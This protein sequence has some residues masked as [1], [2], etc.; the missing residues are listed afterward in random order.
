MSATI[1][2]GGPAFPRTYSTDY[3]SNS[4]AMIETSG[5][6]S[7]RDWFAGQALAGFVSQPDG[8]YSFRWKNTE[9]GETRFLGYGANPAGPNWVVT[10]TAMEAMAEA[11]YKH[12][13]AMIAARSGGAQ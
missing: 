7:L 1:N 6:M 9:T 3:L 2:D 5:G 8:E 10:K 12:A 4:C 11:M 13:D